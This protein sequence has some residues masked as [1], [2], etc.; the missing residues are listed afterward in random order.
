MSWTPEWFWAPIVVVWLAAL[1]VAPVRQA[2]ANGW[3]CVGRHP[4]LWKLPAGFVLVSGLIEL[5][6]ALIFHWRTG[7]QFPLYLPW[8]SELPPLPLVA[9]DS[10]STTAEIL[11]TS[12]NCL[13]APFP[14]SVLCA[15][16]LLANYRGLA[17]ELGLT[18]YRR[19]G[20]W[21]I[22][23]LILLLLCLLAELAKPMCLLAGP[24]IIQAITFRSFIM[25]STVINAMSFTFEYLV[26]T[27]LQLY[28]LLLAYG[29][30]RGLQFDSDKL[31]PFAVRRLGYVTKWALVIIAAAIVLTLLPLLL[32]AWLIKDPEKWNTAVLVDVVGRP[33]LALSMLAM[34]TVQI[35]LALHNDTLRGAMRDHLDFLRRH[36]LPCFLFL[37]AAFASFLVLKT[38]ESIGESYLGESIAGEAW[39]ILMQTGVAALGGWILAAWVCFYTSLQ[40]GAR[41]VSF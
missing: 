13:L 19:F 4:I 3:R 21:S 12:L 5:A 27:C 17:K 36:G 24:Q 41:N 32:E 2:L 29:W 25:V 30:V 15:L 26:G 16:L 22:L 20:A 23:L 8:S 28:L 38:I 11:A 31:L 40:R 33:L 9:V 37:L 34:A 14:L 6:W 7:T 1:C 35:R 39:K 10:L 18:F